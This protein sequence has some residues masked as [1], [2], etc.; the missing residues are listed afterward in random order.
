MGD[1]GGGGV[2]KEQIGAGAWNNGNNE[3]K[4]CLEASTLLLTM[5]QPSMTHFY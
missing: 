1:R 2:W 5:H 3:Y 4:R